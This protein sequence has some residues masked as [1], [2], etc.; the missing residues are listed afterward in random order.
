MRWIKA[1]ER[2][3]KDDKPL[4]IRLDGETYRIGNF[5]ENVNQKALHVHHHGFDVFQDMFDGVEWLDESV[6]P[7]FIVAEVREYLDRL[8][9][10]EITFSRFVELFNTRPSIKDR[11]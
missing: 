9:N 7:P 6:P 8:L 3:P 10:E 1:S 5:Y 4:P 11:E 2:L